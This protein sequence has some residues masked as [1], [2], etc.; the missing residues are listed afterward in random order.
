LLAIVLH[1]V[2]DFN[3]HIPGNAV[4]A[5]TL[6][7]IVISH[8][9]YATERFWL[10]PGI[11]GRL[12][13]TVTILGGVGYLGLQMSKLVPQ[14]YLL[15][16][17]FKPHTWEERLDLLKKAHVIE[18]GNSE[19]AME[20]GIQLR[21][22]AFEGDEGWENVTREAI[23]WFEKG[24]ALNKWNP[25]VY[26]NLGASYDWL[27]EHEKAAPYFEKARE[28]DP[29][30]HY[31]LFWYAWHKLQVGELA[32]ARKFFLDSYNFNHLDNEDAK[33]YVQIVDRM[34]AERAQTQ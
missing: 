12:L 32:E 7:A 27:G 9:R 13:L 30:G 25:F 16:K 26:T 19:V 21:K 34:L 23:P 20:I 14:T 17:F 33:N 1:S 2:T 22:K 6:M 29:N 8:M 5:V 24:G 28:M 15:A 4:V 18:P 3:L 11:I 31:V 10:K